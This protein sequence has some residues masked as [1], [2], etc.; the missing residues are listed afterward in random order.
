[1]EAAGGEAAQSWYQLPA[2][3]DASGFV[4]TLMEA[5]SL[6]EKTNLTSIEEGTIQSEVDLGAGF[7]GVPTHSMHLGLQDSRLSPCLPLLASDSSQAHKL[8]DDT[9]FQQTETEFAPLRAS[10]DTSEFPGPASKSLEMTDAVWLASREVQMDQEESDLFL[11]QPYRE[12]QDGAVDLSGVHSLSQHPLSVSH[13]G[14]VGDTIME[15]IGSNSRTSKETTHRSIE[16][17]LSEDGSFLDSNVPAP[18]LLELLEKEVGMSVGSGTSSR[19]SSQ[20][21]SATEIDNV[22]V[23]PQEHAQCKVNISDLQSQP[24]TRP[25]VNLL[26]EESFRDSS[27]I[28]FEDYEGY[29]DASHQ[30][31][32]SGITLRQSNRKSTQVFQDEL[33]NQLCAE[34]QKNGKKR[35]MSK[36]PKGR[37]HSQSSSQNASV[38]HGNIPDN[39]ENTIEDRPK[40]ELTVSSHYSIERGHKETE[41]SQS[42]NTPVDEASFIGRL[43]HPISQSTPGTFSMGRK[44]LSGRIQ[45]IKAKLTGSN[46]SL[47]EEPTSSSSQPNVAVGIGVPRSAQSSQGNPESSDSQGSLS[48]QRQRIQSLPSLN[49]IEKVG[50]WNTNQSFDALVLRGIT[51]VSPKKMA[52]DAVA[53]SLNRLF[54]RQNSSDTTKK[55]GIATSFKGTSSMTNLNVADKESTSVSQLTRSQSYNSVITVSADNATEK[56]TEVSIVPVAEEGDNDSANSDSVQSSEVLGTSSVPSQNHLNNVTQHHNGASSQTNV[57]PA[58]AATDNTESVDEQSTK[59]ATKPDGSSVSVKKNI[60]TLEHFSDVSLDQDFSGSSHTS[61]HTRDVLQDSAASS[62]FEPSHRHMKPFLEDW[63]RAEKTPE[64]DEFNIEERIPT[65]LRNLG[66]DQSPSTILAPFTPKGPIRE[67]EFS[68]TEL[69]TIKGSTATPS[70]SMKLSEGDSLNAANISQSSL[71]ST[72]S[73]TSV[74]IPLGSEAGQE[75]PLPTELSPQFSSR[76]TSDRPISQDDTATRDVGSIPEA[77]SSQISDGGRKEVPPAVKM[78]SDLSFSHAVPGVLPNLDNIAEDPSY[79][80]QLVDQFESGGVD[81]DQDHLNQA[82]LSS[83]ASSWKMPHHVDSTNDSFVGSKTLKEI[84][85]L[86]AEA[87]D[88]NLDKTSSD[89]DPKYSLKD[90]YI[91]SPVVNNGLQDSLKSNASNSRSASPLDLQL[92]NLSWDTSFN[93]SLRSDGFLRN[94]LSTKTDLLWKDHHV[95][96]FASARDSSN[97]RELSENRHHLPS[98]MLGFH[99]HSRSEPE[100]SSE[101]TANRLVLP[102][103]VHFQDNHTRAEGVLQSSEQ[104]LSSVSRAV[105]GLKHAVDET[106]SGHQRVTGEES[107]ASSGDSLAARVTSLLKSNTLSQTPRVGLPEYEDRKS[108]GSVKLKLTAQSLPADTDLSEEDRRR[109]EEIKRELLVEAQEAVKGY[110][111]SSIES[112]ALR[113]ARGGQKFRLQLT[114]SPLLDQFQVTSD[115]DSLDNGERPLSSPA[116]SGASDVSPSSMTVG[117]IKAMATVASLSDRPPII[118][119]QHQEDPLTDVHTPVSEQVTPHSDRRAASPVKL[120]E[121]PTKP[122]SSITFASRKRTSP[123]STSV[124]PETVGTSS[125]TRSYGYNKSLTDPYYEGKPLTDMHDADK[126]LT[127]LHNKDHQ[128]S[129]TTRADAAHLSHQDASISFPM[130]QDGGFYQTKTAAFVDEN[131]SDIDRSHQ[132]SDLSWM[133]SRNYPLHE[134]RF[135]VTIERSSKSSRLEEEITGFSHDALNI[136]RSGVRELHQQMPDVNVGGWQSYPERVH[137]EK[138]RRDDGYSS[139]SQ[140]LRTEPFTPSSPTRKALSCLRVTI[141]PK[142]D[143]KA[144]EM[145]PNLMASDTSYHVQT[146]GSSSGLASENLSKSTEILTSHGLS[147]VSPRSPYFLHSP[148]RTTQGDNKTSSEDIARRADKDNHPDITTDERRRLLLS[149]ATTQI[150]TESPERTTFSAEIYIDSSLKEDSSSSTVKEHYT[151]ER[152]SS[153]RISFSSLSRATDQ[154]LLLPYRPPGSPELFYIPFM[155]GGSRMSPVSTVES[156]HPGSNDAISPKFS[157]EVLG[158]ATDKH[159]DASIPRHK[160]GIYSQDQSPKTGA[161]ERGPRERR[162]AQAAESIQEDKTSYFSLQ[163]RASYPEPAS[164]YDHKKTSLQPVAED[165]EF[166]PLQ[167]EIDHSQEPRFGMDLPSRY[168]SSEVT[169]VLTQTDKTNFIDAG[170]KSRE[171]PQRKHR[172]DQTSHSPPK[173]PIGSRDSRLDAHEKRDDLAFSSDRL[174]DLRKSL[175]RTEASVTQ[176]VTSSHSL[177][178]LWARYTERQKSQMSES[179]S[180]LETSLVERLDRLARLLQNPAPYSLFVSSDGKDETSKVNKQDHEHRLQAR[181]IEREKLYQKKLGVDP[182]SVNR[183]SRKHKMDNGDISVSRLLESASSENV[184]SGGSLYSDFSS[185]VKSSTTESAVSSEAA[186]QTDS[187]STVGTTS[188]VSTIDTIRLV[189]AFGPER[190]CP[191]SKLSHL[192]DSIDLQRKRSETSKKASRTSAGRGH[193]IMEMDDLQ[194]SLRKMADIDSASSSTTSWEPSPALRSKKSSKMRNKGI[195]AGNL[196]IV[197]SATRR[198]TR[199]VGLTFPSPRGDAGKTPMDPGRGTSSVAAPKS[200]PYIPPGLSWFVPADNMKGDSRK[201]NRPS[202]RAGPAPAWYE[203]MTTTKPWREPLRERNQQDPAMGR[204]APELPTDAASKT[205]RQFVRVTLQESLKAHRPD[206]IFRSGERVKRLQLLSKERKLQNIFQSEREALFNQPMRRE[207]DAHHHAYKESRKWQKMR[208]VPRR[209][210]VQRSKR[211]YE[212]LPEIRKRR[213]EEKRREEYEAY[214]LKAQLF[215]K[216]VTNHI[217]GRKT[218][219]N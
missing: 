89:I 14:K 84:R 218:P 211:I 33:Q 83:L 90:S 124:S 16:D 165:D 41:I 161:A 100:G 64:Q 180:K 182:L 157:A 21:A 51:G 79:V 68:P 52:Y 162:K 175:Q 107:D 173:S 99:K 137:S 35:E 48:P 20:T 164:K 115:Q 80:K 17:L 66:I 30:L 213:E 167:P 81:A 127:D 13:R 214:R 176:S 72:A 140:E 125:T 95:T 112:E 65:Y 49:Y 39:R 102:S 207:G 43:A 141:S 31:E 82:N 155:E 149:D 190:V 73:T 63:S 126:S 139:S 101:A 153:S 203:P 4:S 209:E 212:Q 76:S 61:D 131:Q 45:Q 5:G 210:M 85:K 94:E 55:K 91:S 132:R 59:E 206:F 185:E 138:M 205:V 200:K 77:F 110:K 128:P 78:S 106:W 103:S 62:I 120:L 219:W 123:L 169:S 160:E 184:G 56:K 216:K 178:D 117:N 69:R 189:N 198:G 47:N 119:S 34:I 105:G 145:S 130:E 9:V 15:T 177:D 111:H 156:S 174:S 42:G 192:Y 121:E 144:P 187:G 191:S 3:V 67:P 24:A 148:P 54:S 104:L 116:S 96:S 142:G 87:D 2:E 36:T 170:S 97:L 86:L 75:S 199:D 134:D 70:Q 26:E 37:F 57:D 88:V 58:H 172:S 196:E 215:R 166:F 114:P 201:E 98:P 60:I 92:D 32:Q 27:E 53:D 168:R 158:S 11:A 152:Q 129:E 8:F 197:N 159:P 22:D 44:Q 135:A 183:T 154:P 113:P 19:R 7:P 217:L 181:R 147:S 50:T 193:S 195:Q 10:L 179:N 143:L 204:E 108:R 1:M 29:F 18:V 71:Y 25:V 12:S 194:K 150:T 171:D 122:I 38:L 208:S 188:S 136:E 109:I 133:A 202:V 40:D 46:M 74:S 118:S 93:S 146:I 28:H 151:P 23:P 163:H 186:I 6:A